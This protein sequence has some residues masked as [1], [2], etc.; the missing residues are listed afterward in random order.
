MGS[1]LPLAIMCILLYVKRS[2]CN[3]LSEVYGGFQKGRQGLSRC[4]I[5]GVGG[6]SLPW[7]YVH[8]SICET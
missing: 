6:V 2:W 7:V 8:S 4:S 1:V 5:R 3:G